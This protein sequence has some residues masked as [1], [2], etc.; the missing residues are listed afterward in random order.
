MKV[1]ITKG[2]VQ[3]SLG[4]LGEASRENVAFST[5]VATIGVQG[6][7]FIIDVGSDD[8]ASLPAEEQKSQQ[9]N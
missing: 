6:T 2:L 9:L 8:A 3:A 5:P 4:V 7:T 1:N